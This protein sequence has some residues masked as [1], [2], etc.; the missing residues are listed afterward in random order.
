MDWKEGCIQ[1]QRQPDRKSGQKGPILMG[2]SLVENRVSLL[3]LLDVS[4]K[5]RYR[6][7][8]KW[9]VQCIPFVWKITG[10]HCTNLFGRSLSLY[11]GN[12]TEGAWVAGAR[13]ESTCRVY[14]AGGLSVWEIPSILA[15]LFRPMLLARAGVAFDT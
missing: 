1:L 11:R 15:L 14:E 12:G 13:C 7:R 5:E 10:F 8:K 2:K 9:S 6:L 4:G 3:L